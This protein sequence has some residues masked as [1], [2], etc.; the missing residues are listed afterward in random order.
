MVRPRSIHGERRALG[1]YDVYLIT[2]FTWAIMGDVLLHV[3]VQIGTAIDRV[4]EI[5]PQNSN[6]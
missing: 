6:T 5:H 3:S 1:R 4:V 2:K